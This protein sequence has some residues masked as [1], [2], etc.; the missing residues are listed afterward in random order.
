MFTL[1][2]SKLLY[3]C[4]Q[5]KTL[6]KNFTK[7]LNLFQEICFRQNLLTKIENLDTLT[8]LTQLELY[9]NQLTKI[10]NLDS[11]VNLEYTI[12]FHISIW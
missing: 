4:V 11:L 3:F 1:C 2:Q 7:T 8:T 5:V 9:D 12:T 10:E 6:S